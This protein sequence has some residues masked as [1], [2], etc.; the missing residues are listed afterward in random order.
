LAARGL[1][2]RVT[3]ADGDFLLIDASTACP[4][5]WLESPDVG[6]HRTWIR[7]GEARFIAEDL[8]PPGKCMSWIM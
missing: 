6:T 8:C 1:T 2:A 4:H 7:G 3:D 5:A